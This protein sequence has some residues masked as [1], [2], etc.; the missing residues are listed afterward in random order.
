MISLVAQLAL[1]IWFF[2]CIKSYKTSKWIL[3]KGVG[4]KSAEFAV[5]CLFTTGVVLYH[6]VYP[7]GKWFLLFVL[8]CWIIVQFFCHWYFTIFGVSEK[9]LK[10]YNECF[11]DTVRFIPASD[12][13]L[14]PD[15]YHTILHI[16]ILINIV[17]IFLQR[18][19]V[20]YEL[21]VLGCIDKF[22]FI[23]HKPMT[24]PCFLRKNLL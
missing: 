8:S 10:G 23:A 9:K 14:I 6:A 22:Q 13:K 24:H 17:L 1:W 2:G 19:G 11:S 12:T 16:L 18:S 20:S 21:Q 3:S 15:L 7:V 5:L 4:I